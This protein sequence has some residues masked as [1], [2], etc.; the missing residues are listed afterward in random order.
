MIA[1]PQYSI[2]RCDRPT[3]GGGLCFFVRNNISYK[4][5]NIDYIRNRTLEQLWISLK[6]NKINMFVGILY[7]PPLTNASSFSE[8]EAVLSNI[9]PIADQVIVMGD[10]NVVF[11]KT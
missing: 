5:I 1:I 9:Y 10:T 4:L 3:R 8:L 7:K 11:H 2:V 6:V